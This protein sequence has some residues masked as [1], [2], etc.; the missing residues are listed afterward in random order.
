[1]WGGDGADGVAAKEAIAKTGHTPVAE[2]PQWARDGGEDAA[3]ERPASSQKKKRLCDGIGAP[4]DL[5]AGSKSLGDEDDSL[6]QGNGL[7][8]E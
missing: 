3:E 6:L 2:L 1:L 5:L 8:R 7:G 4:M